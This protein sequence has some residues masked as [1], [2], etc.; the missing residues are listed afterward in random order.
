[1]AILID[2]YKRY[3]TSKLLEPPAVMQCTHDYQRTND[4]MADFVDC[5]IERV[6]APPPA[7]GPS[8]TPAVTTGLTIDDAMAEIKVWITSDNVPIKAPKKQLLQRYLD[9]VLGK[10]VPGGKG[11]GTRGL[12]YIGWRIRSRYGDDD[13]GM[14]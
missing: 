12:T 4:H 7:P 14:D 9:R 2:Y 10:G 3:V 8:L 5:C 13:D 1:M 6:P 11:S